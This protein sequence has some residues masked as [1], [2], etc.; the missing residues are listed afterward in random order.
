MKKIKVA[1]IGA[2]HLGKIHSR[3]YSQCADANL[4]GICDIDEEKAKT[5]ALNFNTAFLCNYKDL[6][7]KVDAVSIATPTC[8]HFQI[9]KDFL[10][11]NI[12]VMIEKPITTT[13]K[14]A[15]ILIKLAK[16]KKKI[17]QVGHV[18]RFN[19]AIKIIQRLC[20]NP[21]FIE[22]HRLSPFP[23]RSTDIGVVLDLMIHDIDIILSLIKFPLK[24]IHAVGVDVLSSYD[25]IANARLIFKNGTVCNL[26]ASRISN[27]VMRKIRIFQKDSY[28]SIDYAQQKIIFFR[29]NKVKITRKEIFVP[30]K[31]PLAEELRSFL[32]CIRNNKQ[33]LVCGRDAKDALDIALTITK[34]IQKHHRKSNSPKKII[35][36]SSF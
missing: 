19:P 21:Q 4:T 10:N 31:E 17:L 30:K 36:K 11:N 27:D 33:P 18:E 35:L 34:Q 32:K 7:G 6:I 2:G 5:H 24:S 28:I 3:I 8:T 12:H 26:T 13:L 1:V 16:K 9:A 25:D 29:K 22:C 15:E 14:D 23:K 20:K